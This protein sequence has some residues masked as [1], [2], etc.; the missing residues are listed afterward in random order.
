VSETWVIADTH[1]G[2]RNII[3]FKREDGSPLRPFASVEEHDAALIENWNRVVA[4][5]DRVYHLGDVVINRRCLSTLAQLNG[6][7][8]LVR[9]NHDIWN[10]KDFAPYFDDI[11]GVRVYPKIRVILS[12]IP[13]HPSQLERWKCNVHG[14]LHYRSLDDDRY[15]N[16]CVE[17]IGYTP[18][19]LQ[20]IIDG[21]D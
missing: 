11:V 15:V 2:H 8:K 7:K 3:N 20:E 1:F 10:M 4:P 16:V 12:H 17:H 5:K 6:R 19:N 14:H 18:K 21:L 13:L 9:G